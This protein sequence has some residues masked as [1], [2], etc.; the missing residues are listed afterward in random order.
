MDSIEYF[1]KNKYVFIPSLVSKDITEFIYNYL[2]LKSCTNV[3]FSEGDQNK[4][5]TPTPYLRYCYA[6]LVTET[7]T[8]ILLKPLSDVTQKKLIPTYSYTR[9]YTRGE[10]LKP[11]TDRSSCQYSVTINF[12]GDPWSIYFG[13]LNKG[14]DFDNG[15]SMLN[16]IVLKPGDG[17]IYMGEE[18]VHWRNEFKGDHCAQAFL[19]YIDENGPYFPEYAYDK[20]PNI[21][22]K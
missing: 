6:D 13:E 3:D 1:K 21:G 16:E 10:I 7:L 14:D 4:N 15:F 17:I 9:V 19:H 8:S 18:L 5:T 2:I 12:G 22:Y 11:H 20:R